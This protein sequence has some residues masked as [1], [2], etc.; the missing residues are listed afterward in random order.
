M[1]KSLDI[2][3]IGESLI[4]LSCDDNLSSTECF[5]KYYGG[6]TLVT[7]VTARRLGG[8][9]GF[10]TKVGDDAF[11]DYLIECWEKEGLDISHVK[12]AEEQNGV[13]FIT[14]P[15]VE[16]KELVYYRKKIAQSKFSV[17]DVSEE[18]LSSAR[19]LYTSGITQS[20]SLSAK[21]AVS[22]AYSIARKN[23]VITAYDP[24]YS[25]TIHT[26]ETIKENFNSVVSD[27][28]I[29]FMSTKNDTVCILD[30]DSVEGIIKYLWDMGVSTVVL[31]SG[32][33]GGYYTGYN[34]EI[35]FTEFYTKEVVDTTCSGDCFNGAFLYGITHGYTPFQ[36]SKLA[37]IT[38]GLQAKGMG[39]VKSVP[40]AEDVFPLLREVKP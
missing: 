6:D 40:Y 27:V 32:K 23:G 10:I 17:S 36:S 24:N 30:L 34:G 4:E 7:A 26:P 33:D 29:M 14:K 28:D 18:Y 12:I 13:Y 8:K 31:K 35:N 25:A 2:I 22:L 15:G 37:S 1:D 19:V 21:E 20:I 38:A 9:V 39:A 11:K 3:T 16:G 5:Y